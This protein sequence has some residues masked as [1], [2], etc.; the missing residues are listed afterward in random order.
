MSYGYFMC[1][2]THFYVKYW[3]GQFQKVSRINV[4]SIIQGSPK[5]VKF[6]D[7]YYIAEAKIKNII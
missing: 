5:T 1:I 3:G 4:C 2:F 6:N 7:I